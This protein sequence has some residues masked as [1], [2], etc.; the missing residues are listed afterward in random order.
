MVEQE[1]STER[2]RLGWRLFQLGEAAR[3]QFD[4]RYRAEP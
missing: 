3:A 2:Y 1:H 4:L